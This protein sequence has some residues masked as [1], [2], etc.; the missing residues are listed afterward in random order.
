MTGPSTIRYVSS[1]G[2]DTGTCTSPGT[3]C[4]TVSFAIAHAASG[5]TIEVAGTV[6]DLVTV[7]SNM[8]LTVT[9]WPGQPAAVLDATDDG[10]VV[11]V[12]PGDTVALNGLT[13]QGGD[14]GQAGAGGGINNSGTLTVTNSTISDNQ[15]SSGGG[16]YNTGTL[17]ITSSTISDNTSTLYDGGGLFVASGTVTVTNSTISGN[18]A[19][20]ANSGVSSGGGIYNHG[21]TLTVSNST[22]S[23]NTAANGGG[24]IDNGATLTVTSSTISN[25]NAIHE[26]SL[27]FPY[28]GGIL[29]YGT[30]VV[31]TVTNSTISGNTATAGAGIYSSG[32]GAGVTIP[33]A[34]SR[35]TRPPHRTVPAASSKGATAGRWAPPSWPAMPVGTAV[36]TRLSVSAT[37]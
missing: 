30:G 3:P 12:H 29:S 14:G 27:S 18:T 34:R 6:D 7:P 20:N 22:I 5:D 23:G 37:T 33:P 24:G 17:T 9:Q 19:I 1:G 15:A 25:N 32:A 4:G 31:A 21:G 13:I 26:S 2:T 16:V 35:A 10:L 8:S 28:G 11:V 36:G